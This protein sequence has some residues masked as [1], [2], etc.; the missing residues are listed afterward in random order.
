MSADDLSA[1]KRMCKAFAGDCVD[2]R[3]WRGR[4]CLMIFPLQR[5]DDLGPDQA[6]SANDYDLH[7][8]TSH[9]GSNSGGSL[10]S[11]FDAYSAARVASNKN[12]VRRSASS[13]QAQS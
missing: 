2:T 13:I 10:P 7:D 1:G 11:G 9:D 3:V 12:Q 5:R 8:L 4:N 6:G